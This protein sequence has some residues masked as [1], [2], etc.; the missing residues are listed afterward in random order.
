[1]RSSRLCAPRWP[2]C[3]VTMD[4]GTCSWKN[5]LILWELKDIFCFVRCNVLVAVTVKTTVCCDVTPC[6]LID[7]CG[8]FGWICCLVFP[9]APTSTKRPLSCR[10]SNQNPAHTFPFY[11]ACHIHGLLYLLVFSRLQQHWPGI[12]IIM[13]FIMQFSAPSFYF[14]LLRIRNYPQHRTSTQLKPVL[15]SV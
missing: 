7:E 14:R 15:F 2:W 1:M 5:D 6:D 9:S 12:Q 4:K 8:R 11:R 10:F 13:L 3:S